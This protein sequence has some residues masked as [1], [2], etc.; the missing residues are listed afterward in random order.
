[1]QCP[2]CKSDMEDVEVYEVIVQ[3]C[4]ACKGMFFDRSKHEYLKEKEDAE[5]AA[6][7]A[8]GVFD[9]KNE[10]KVQFYTEFA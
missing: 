3:R 8:P 4:T 10:L 2:K 1:M 6:Y 5:S 9:V 7:M